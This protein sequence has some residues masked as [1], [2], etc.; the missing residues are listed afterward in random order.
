MRS[1]KE[2][3]FNSNEDDSLSDSFGTTRNLKIGRLVG[4]G[5][6]FEKN[7][8][9]KSRKGGG[10]IDDIFLHDKCTNLGIILSKNALIN[11]CMYF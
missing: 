11:L 4:I 8:L 10:V 6:I 5:G 9:A 3:Q 1:K 7:V 2:T